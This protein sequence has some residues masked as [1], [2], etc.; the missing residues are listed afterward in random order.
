MVSVLALPDGAAIA[1]FDGFR[2]GASVGRS[3]VAMT[4]RY[5]ALP[6]PPFG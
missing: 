3:P 6:L 5:A 1:L 2:F 4:M